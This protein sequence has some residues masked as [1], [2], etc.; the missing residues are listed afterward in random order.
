M[1]VTLALALA[2][3]MLSSKW[4]QEKRTM[5]NTAKAAL[6][7][8]ATWRA[9]SAIEAWH[10]YLGWRREKLAQLKAAVDRISGRSLR[11][12]LTAW[13]V[14]HQHVGRFLYSEMNCEACPAPGNER[15]AR[16]PRNICE[17]LDSS[18]FEFHNLIALPINSLLPMT[19]TGHGCFCRKSQCTAGS[20]KQSCVSA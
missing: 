9:A 16:R 6:Q 4:L 10:A 18:W 20:C 8:M 11:W 7:R 12:M 1:H 14:S 3:G 17:C 19:R 2:N 13:Q 5:A 15:E